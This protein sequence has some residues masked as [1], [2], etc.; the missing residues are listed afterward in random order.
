MKILNQ[1]H[2][3]YTMSPN[4]NGEITIHSQE[5]IKIHTKDC[6]TEKIKDEYTIQD[7]TDI[8]PCSGPILIE[9]A[10]AG[11]VLKI[12]I[13]D[14]QIIGHVKM[15]V[16]PSFGII[17]DIVEKGT[18]KYMPIENNQAIFNENYRIDLEPMI[19]TIGVALKEEDILTVLP[20][21]H[22]GNMDCKKIKAGNTL[23]LP[24]FVDKAKLYLG[25]IHAFM[26]DGE[27]VCG[28]ES[29]SITTLKIT[30]LKDCDY[31]AP[32][33]KEKNQLMIITSDKTLEKSIQKGLYK[34]HAF[35]K[36]HSLLSNEEI[37]LLMMAKADLR[38]NQIANA[39]PTIRIEI[40]MDFFKIQID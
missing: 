37:Y 14:I 15:R 16:R 40:P 34:T 33:L 13:L 5:T 4:H 22:G 11:D 25:D 8:N 38:I 26:N 24:V 28:G 9:E 1:N 36:Q 19:G 10:K 27:I 12:E 7:I 20:G 29:N 31:P 39:I 30:V 6:Y 3:Y 2:Y 35:L 18:Q 21:D 17:G 23:Y 32:C